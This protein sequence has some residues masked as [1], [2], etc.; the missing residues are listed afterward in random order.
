MIAFAFLLNEPD[1]QLPQLLVST[2][3]IFFTLTT[4]TFVKKGTTCT[5]LTKIF[6]LLKY[7]PLSFINVL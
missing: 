5:M 3:Q 6:L 4:L 7:L 2:H 1:F